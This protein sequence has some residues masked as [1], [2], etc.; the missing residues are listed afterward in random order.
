[1]FRLRT[2]QGFVIREIGVEENEEKCV[3]DCGFKISN[4]Q[5]YF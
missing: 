5:V 4:S 1:M 2:S 3:D